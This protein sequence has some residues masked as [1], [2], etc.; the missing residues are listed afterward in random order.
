MELETLEAFCQ[1]LGV[2]VQVVPK[3][4]KIIPPSQNKLRFGHDPSLQKQKQTLGYLF[5]MSDR[6]VE[7]E[8]GAIVEEEE[9]CWE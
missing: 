1:S 4:T 5:E 2:F 6:E 9:T 3:G 7:Y 8:L